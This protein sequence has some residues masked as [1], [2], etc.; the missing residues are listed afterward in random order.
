[1]HVRGVAEAGDGYY[2]VVT[3]AIE[4][5]EL[6]TVIEVP[7]VLEDV[8]AQGT[9]VFGSTSDL[10]LETGSGHDVEIRPLLR[11]KV[12]VENDVAQVQK[13]AKASS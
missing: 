6:L 13:E 4:E 9:N 5:V 7:A 2:V 10:L 3:L 1:M 12:M 11:E 8:A